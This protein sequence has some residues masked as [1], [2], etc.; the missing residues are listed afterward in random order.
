MLAL[1]KRME[2][3]EMADTYDVTNA[4]DYKDLKACVFSF[5]NA[6]VIV[7]ET[8]GRLVMVAI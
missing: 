4:T 8:G 1:L 6:N 2:R 3:L 5:T 7:K